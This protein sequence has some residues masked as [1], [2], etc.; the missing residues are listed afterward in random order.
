MTDALNTIQLR[1]MQNTIV[2]KKIDFSFGKNYQSTNSMTSYNAWLELTAV[3]KLN[4]YQN[5][6]NQAQPET[7]R[8]GED[9]L[10]P[11]D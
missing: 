6:P 7:W 10:Y 5:Q 2:L 4:L 1:H 11:T 3:F 9:W 8:Q